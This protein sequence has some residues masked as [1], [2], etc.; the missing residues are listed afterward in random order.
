MKPFSRGTHTKGHFAAVFFL[1]E[2]ES[3]IHHDKSF[4]RGK[5]YAIDTGVFWRRNEPFVDYV[6]LAL[7]PKEKRKDFKLKKETLGREK[8]NAFVYI[9]LNLHI[10]IEHQRASTRAENKTKKERKQKNHVTDI[11]ETQRENCTVAPT[12]WK[13]KQWFTGIR[14]ERNARKQTAK[15]V[16]VYQEKLSDFCWAKRVLTPRVRSQSG[17]FQTKMKR[18]PLSKKALYANQGLVRKK[19]THTHV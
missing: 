15:V 16:Q 8:N 6:C 11:R 3:E 13:F 7:Q 18:F 10:Q 4:Q 14:G 1:N 19:N 17:K 9:Y 2:T 12:E 5:S